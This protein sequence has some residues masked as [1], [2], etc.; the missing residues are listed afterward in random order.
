MPFE[1]ERDPKDLDRRKKEFERRLDAMR[2]E[3]KLNPEEFEELLD[4]YR[5]LGKPDCPG[6]RYP[7]S[8]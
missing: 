6:E 5:R 1:F 8:G 3:L 2:E 4:G 7:R